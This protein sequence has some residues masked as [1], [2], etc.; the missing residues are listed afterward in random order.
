MVKAGKTT[1]VGN[2]A[3]KHTKSK[4]PATTHSVVKVAGGSGGTVHKLP[5]SKAVA[6]EPETPVRT[7]SNPL[8][9]KPSFAARRSPELKPRVVALTVST[10]PEDLP[11]KH[12]P[13]P[14]H[15]SPPKVVKVIR[16]VR[17]T[18]K[19]PATC[20]KKIPRQVPNDMGVEGI[21]MET[22][23]SRHHELAQAPHNA[24][25]DS[26]AERSPPLKETGAFAGAC[27]VGAAIGS[28]REQ[29]YL[30]ERQSSP[31]KR[32]PAQPTEKSF[33]A[34]AKEPKT[35]CAKRESV[36]AKGTTKSGAK[37]NPPD[38]HKNVE[39]R[40]ATSVEAAPHLVK[41][42]EGSCPT[43]PPHSA[44]TTIA[45]GS[46][47]KPEDASSIATAAHTVEPQSEVLLRQQESG[48]A[49][50]SS[51][52]ATEE[53]ISPAIHDLK[54][55]FEPDLR[56]T[57]AESLG[58]FFHM[59]RDQAELLLRCFE[60][61]A[62][63]VG[64]NRIAFSVYAA[65]VQGESNFQEIIA[66]IRNAEQ[67]DLSWHTSVSD[68]TLEAVAQC[69]N[70]KS[71]DLSYCR[72]ITRVDVLACLHS[73]QY[74]KLRNCVSVPAPALRKLASLEELTEL[75]LGGVNVDNETLVLLATSLPKLQKLTCFGAAVARVL[76]PI[77]PQLQLFTKPEDELTRFAKLAAQAC[78]T[79][80]LTLESV[81]ACLT[82]TK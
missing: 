67:L 42:H 23:K 56:F 74:L 39:K 81:L 20:H 44:S 22:A 13:K 76:Q 68:C 36:D 63:R 40:P 1:V 41:N 58:I 72:G 82:G 51:E 48:N 32:S 59:D 47:A 49:A 7:A 14:D 33:N 57:S 24:S 2:R 62:L 54:H 25:Q 12:H 46:A 45:G 21:H 79:K 78:T 75:D 66:T 73:L 53:I 5:T 9:Q 31:T 16:L 8:K 34:S 61:P 10:P 29:S 27:V 55:F 70:L 43:G 26:A 69:K 60:I 4:S 65:G 80:C 15:K 64:Y 37:A 6:V 38:T 19:P 18:T 17:P 30:K 71:L 50:S 52:A 28:K 3:V 77:K 35:E 11:R